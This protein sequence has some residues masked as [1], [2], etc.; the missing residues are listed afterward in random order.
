MENEEKIIETE[1]TQEET[2][3]ETP[4][5]KAKNFFKRTYDKGKE[6]VKK[7]YDNRETIAKTV[8]GIAGGVT[9]VTQTVKTVKRTFGGN[10]TQYEKTVEQRKTQYYDPSSRRYIPLRREPSDY[11]LYEIDRRRATGEPVTMILNDLGLLRRS[12]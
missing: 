11:E 7:A 12:W 1:V 5:E 10:K 9:L 4:K 2:V 6:V 8:V 3:E